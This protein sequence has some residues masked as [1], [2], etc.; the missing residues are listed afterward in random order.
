MWRACEEHVLWENAQTTQMSIRILA[1][2]ED[3]DSWNLVRWWCSSGS[4]PGQTITVSWVYSSRPQQQSLIPFNTRALASQESRC[5]HARGIQRLS[6]SVQIFFGAQAGRNITKRDNRWHKNWNPGSCRAFQVWILLFP[7][8]PA[9]QLPF[10]EAHAKSCKKERSELF[11]ELIQMFDQF[12]LVKLLSWPVSQLPWLPK[13]HSHSSAGHLCRTR[14]V[15]C[16]LAQ[17]GKSIGV[18]LTSSW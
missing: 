14:A 11:T 10:G 4:M 18:W 8:E 2:A 13:R 1:N 5:W 7:K 6:T 12:W 16:D 9:V 3:T 15:G 17:A